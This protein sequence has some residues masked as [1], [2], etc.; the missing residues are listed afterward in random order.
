MS[1]SNTNQSNLATAEAYYAALYSGDEDKAASYLA[2]DV[3][4]VDRLWP[5]TGKGRV[6]PVG[7]SFAAAVSQ[8]QPTAKF[9]NDNQV[10]LVGDVI[11]KASE[12]PMRAAVLMTF[13]DGLIKEIELIYDGSEHMDICINIHTVG[14]WGSLASAG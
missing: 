4:Y 10:M 5:Q 2:S 14:E 13:G 3:K 6:W 11:W 9:S 7:K 1:Q 12:K 8:W